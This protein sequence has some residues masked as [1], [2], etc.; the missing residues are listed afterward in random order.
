MKLYRSNVLSVLTYGCET[1]QLTQKQIDNISSFDHTCLRKILKIKWSDKVS[2][3]EVRKIAAIQSVTDI[4][5]KQ[6]LQWFGHIIRMDRER[7]PKQILDWEPTYNN[8]TRGRPQQ[9]WKDTITRD[10]ES[11]NITYEEAKYIAKNKKD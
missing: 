4:M 2:N 9:S 5:K 1:W 10:F 8:T 7:I 3:E 6:R 11:M